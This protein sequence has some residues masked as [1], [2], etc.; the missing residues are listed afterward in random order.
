VKA[1]GAADDVWLV[2]QP[3]T[4][5]GQRLFEGVERLKVLIG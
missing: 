5:H 3:V 1:G 4:A 2:L